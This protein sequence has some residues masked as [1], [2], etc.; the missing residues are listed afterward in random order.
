METEDLDSGEGSYKFSD[1]FEV[2]FVIGQ[3]AFG[4]VVLAI[5]KETGEECAVK[6]RLHAET[7]FLN[8][9]DHL[10]EDYQYQRARAIAKGS[11]YSFEL[12]AS[13]HREIP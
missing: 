9:T 6:V 13:E 5:D 8:Y 10:Q 3:G 2:K 11:P 4:K 7:L 12:E 1:Y